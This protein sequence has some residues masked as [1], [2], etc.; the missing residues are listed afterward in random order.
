[1]QSSRT[2][3]KRPHVRSD[4]RGTHQ[5]GYREAQSDGGLAAKESHPSRHFISSAKGQGKR[6]PSHPKRPQGLS[7]PHAKLNSS[8]KGLLHLLKKGWSTR[9]RNKSCTDATNTSPPDGIVP[10]SGSSELRTRDYREVEKRGRPRWAGPGG[11]RLI[12]PPGLSGLKC[13]TL[14]LLTRWS[15]RNQRRWRA[16][17]CCCPAPCRCRTPRPRWP[18]G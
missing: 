4:A 9:N 15:E 16:N 12:H 1:L 18:P 6:P 3:V 2:G 7:T 8:Y 13:R 14:D 11:W 17:R 10:T 5:H